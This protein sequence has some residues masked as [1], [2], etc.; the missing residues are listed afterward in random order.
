ML[1]TNLQLALLAVR[2]GH[3]RIAK[4]LL[5]TALGQANSEQPALRTHILTALN[6]ARCL[7]LR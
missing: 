4:A 3:A 1:T 2:L 7:P 5:T 6:Y